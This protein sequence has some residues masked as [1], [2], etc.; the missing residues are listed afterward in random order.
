MKK[1]D[2][3]IIQDLLPL[4]VDDVC[5]E[6]SKELVDSHIQYCDECFNDLS[7]M[8]ESI[9]LTELDSNS[10][11]N[12]EINIMKKIKISIMKRNIK[13]VAI[14]CAFITV[15]FIALGFY[16]F[17]HEEVIS[18]K[19]ISIKVNEFGPEKNV[20]YT[21]PANNLLK[22]TEETL[23]ET[24]DTIYQSINLYL[25][26]T[27]YTKLAKPDLKNYTID[28]FQDYVDY[29]DI[30][31]PGEKKIY[32]PVEIYYTDGISGEKHLLWKAEK[33]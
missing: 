8:K 2:C 17:K 13:L 33:Y 3:D 5:S 30:E 18:Y 19:D 22:Y 4:Y 24:D 25:T 9:F 28:K 20:I 10:D 26:K 16:I 32:K 6:K 7:I 29:P 15:A 12:T 11:I 1:A 14:G 27:P 23:K 31:N 21:G